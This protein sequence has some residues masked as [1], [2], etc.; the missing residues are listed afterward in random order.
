ML[1]LLLFVTFLLSPFL[2]LS[3][4][5]RAGQIRIVSTSNLTVRFQVRMLTDMKSEIRFGEGVFNF[6]DGATVTSPDL[7][8]N[9]TNQNTVGFVE[10]YT[11]HTYSNYGTYIVSYL[12][13]NLTGGMINL[14]NSVETRFYIESGF[15]LSP[16]SSFESPAF[17]T[18]PIFLCPL[19][20]TYSFSTAT[21][22]SAAD[23]YYKYTL[24][25][26]AL[27]DKD[28]PIQGYTIP[29]NF[30]IN[31]TNGLVSWDTK[32][33]GVFTQGEFWI[34]IKIDKYNKTGFH[35]GFVI[36]AIQIIV[37]ERDTELEI[38]SSVT[39][40]DKRIVVTDGQEKKIKV[41][42][43]NDRSST[44][45][46]FEVYYSQ[47]IKGN[48]VVSQYDSIKSGRT[49]R[50]AVLTLK[51]TSNILSDFPYTISL[52]GNSDVSMDISFLYL[53]KDVPFPPQP[54]QPVGLGDDRIF[55]VYPNPFY[56]ELY[57]EGLPS[58]EA[59]LIN[60]SGQVVMKLN[61]RDGQP[62]NTASLPH[63]LYILKTADNTVHRLI[64]N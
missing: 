48:I 38:S 54:T 64:H 13:P 25:A 11:E 3:T 18:D 47:G 59:V 53:T 61:L 2:A 16:G 27:K 17:P 15:T 39:D 21:V 19:G 52:R 50:V 46:G 62:I 63:G 44:K 36:R 30:K 10:W 7:P 40:P 8:N 20:R 26:Q 5:I 23:N 31:E 37:E 4:H 41:L 55:S 51:T 28:Q 22:D 42:L 29:E 9:P 60:A 14:F 33:K 24:P 58:T 45:L 43:Y 1:R 56:S 32:Y 57:V 35:L 49:F 34:W 6:G 12:E